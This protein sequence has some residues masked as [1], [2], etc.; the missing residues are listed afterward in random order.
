MYELISQVM[1]MVHADCSQIM[2][3]LLFNFLLIFNITFRDTTIKHLNYLTTHQALADL[4]TFIKSMNKQ[5]ELPEGTKWIV[6]GGSY[7]G[8]LAAWMRMKYPHLVHGAVSSSAPV[9]AQLDFPGNTG[10]VGIRGSYSLNI[11]LSFSK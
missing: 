1:K 4:A 8:N 9:L 2:N 7:A 10:V 11:K 3:N 5:N 6:F